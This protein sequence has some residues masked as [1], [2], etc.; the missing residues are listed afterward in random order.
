MLFPFIVIAVE[1]VLAGLFG[2]HL[3]L[4][5]RGACL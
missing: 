5:S 1:L 4:K 3:G 2:I